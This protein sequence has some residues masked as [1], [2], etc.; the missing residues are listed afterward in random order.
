MLH[1]KCALRAN[2]VLILTMKLAVLCCNVANELFFVLF[3]YVLF[4]VVKQYHDRKHAFHTVPHGADVSAGVLLVERP[5][6]RRKT[7]LVI[8]GT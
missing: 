7:P 5:Y 1:V 4:I 3:L 8:G 6:C 2:V